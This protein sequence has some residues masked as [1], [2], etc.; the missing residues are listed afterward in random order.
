MLFRFVK[1][2]IMVRFRL[3]SVRDALTVAYAGNYISD[4]VF[5]L[6]YEDS[7]EYSE[8]QHII[9]YMLSPRRHE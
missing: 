6:L 7:L 8:K 1:I 4:D 2:M 3:Q 5:E 9:R